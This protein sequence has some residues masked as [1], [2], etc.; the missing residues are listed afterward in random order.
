[1][2]AIDLLEYRDKIINAFEKGIFLFEQAK[3]ESKD[4]LYDFVLED[5][6]KLIQKIESV[7]KNINLS[8]F[9][10]FFKSSPVDYAKYLINLKNTEEN[11]EFANE[12]K[13]RIASL[14]EKIKEMSVKEKKS[15]HGQ[16]TEDH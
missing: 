10:E 13:N 6:N 9:N 15:K 2:H 14:K 1:M 7:S 12:M 3:E 8:L 11:K 5:V 16:N 4:V